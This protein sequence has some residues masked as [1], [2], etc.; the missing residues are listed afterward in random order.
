MAAKQEAEGSTLG[1]P[2]LALEARLF[3]V[4]SIQVASAPYVGSIDILG[5]F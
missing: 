2:E 3:I 4:E 1:K 5:V